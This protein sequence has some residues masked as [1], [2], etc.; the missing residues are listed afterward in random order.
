MRVLVTNDDGIGA[1]GLAVSRQIAVELAGSPDR[2]WTVAPAWDRSGAGQGVTYTSI[3]RVDQTGEQEYSVAGTPADCVI[4][5][6]E[7]LLGGEFPEVVL[8]G[9]NRGHN[10]ADDTILSGT[11]GG[12]MAAATRGI[13]AFAL[14]QS[15]GAGADADD[16]WASAREHGAAVVR[17]LL[18]LECPPGIGF[19]INF[20]A[21][22]RGDT[23]GVRLAPLGK[24][25]RGSL[26]V[27]RTESSRS[28]GMYFLH[29]HS[30][31]K[32]D[33]TSVPDSDIVLCREGWIT[34][35]PLSNDLTAR[36]WLGP[37]LAAAIDSGP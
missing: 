8:S 36:D 13:G 9:V 31:G 28:A 25:Y 15:Y 24:W 18:Q 6:A 11:V 4:I 33:S 17:K 29:G 21:R 27:S 12:A 35:T 10:V 2:V 19:N 34:V 7:S 37:E 16:P 1:P 22:G 23:R 20:P 26:R 3:I 32:I 5:G 14:S 30:P